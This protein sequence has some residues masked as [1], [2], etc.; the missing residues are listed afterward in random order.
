MGPGGHLR[1]EQQMMGRGVSASEAPDK[2]TNL[3]A[4]ANARLVPVA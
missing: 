1:E 4:L 2:R 3:S